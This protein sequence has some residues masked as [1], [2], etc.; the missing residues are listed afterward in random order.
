MHYK[1]MGMMGVVILVVLL[2]IKLSS[3]EAARFGFDVICAFDDLGVLLA[4]YTNRK[5]K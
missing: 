3:A 2:E 5:E 1:K 4:Y